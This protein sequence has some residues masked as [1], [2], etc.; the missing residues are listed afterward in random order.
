MKLSGRSLQLYKLWKG[1]P[2]REY[3]VLE[4][5]EVYPDAVPELLWIFKKAETSERFSPFI[6]VT[7][8]KGMYLKRTGKQLSPDFHSDVM[9]I[10]RYIMDLRVSY[11]ARNLFINN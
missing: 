8:G 1:I 4:L 2:I 10:L 6:L 7:I 9:D 5:K 11:I 3:K